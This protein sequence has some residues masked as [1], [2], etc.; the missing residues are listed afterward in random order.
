MVVTFGG[1]ELKNASKIANTYS[2]RSGVTVLATGKSSIQSSSEFG[3]GAT[4]RCLG[5][6]ADIT[7][8]LALVGT[9]GTLTIGAITTFSSAYIVGDIKVD[10]SK[11]PGWYFYTVNIEEETI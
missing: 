8:L 1:V 10:E 4:F 7:A 9:P 5:E 11:R 2:T 3:R 6:W